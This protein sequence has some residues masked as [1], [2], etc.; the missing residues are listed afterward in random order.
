MKRADPLFFERLAKGQ[1]PA[2]FWIG[3]SDSR[4]PANEIVGLGPGEVFVHRNGANLVLNTDLNMLA[5]LQF[6]VEYLKVK[7]IIV[8]GHYDCAGV[9]AALKSQ[10]LGTLEHW[11]CNIRDVV[12]LHQKE[13]Y[14]IHD[15]E[16]RVERLV[17]LNVMEQAGNVF[18]T[19]IVQRR[20]KETYTSGGVAFPRVH[21]L[22]F[23]PGTGALKPVPVDFKAMV[24]KVSHI[25]DLYKEGK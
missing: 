19:G 16:Q 18:K 13:L 9:R 15:M 17:E 21:G 20:R 25:Y 7:H 2:H 24:R 4:V 1:S 12:R 11:V 22:V 8:C 10:D 23:N 5:C 6:A 14:S 3:C